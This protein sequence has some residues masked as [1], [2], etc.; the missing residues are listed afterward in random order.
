MSEALDMHVASREEQAA[1]HRNVFDIWSLGRSLDDHVAYRL[2]SP[3]HRLATWYVGCVDCRVVV[4]LGAYP[5]QFQLQGQRLPGFA[6]GSVYTIGDFRGRGYAPQL[7]SWVERRQWQ[8]GAALSLLYSDIKPEY[9]AR[10]GY[11]LCPSLEGRR[12]LAGD[13]PA[14]TDARLVEFSAA[15]HVQE[16]SKL[17][18]AYHG[19]LP[20]SIARDADYWQALLARMPDDRFFRLDTSAGPWQGYVRLARKDATWRITDYALAD[21][22]PTLAEQL[23]SASLHLARV[24]GAE[25]FGGWLPDTPAARKLFDLAPRQTEITMIK[26]LAAIGIPDEVIASA[27]HFCEV[28]HV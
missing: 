9:Y 19:A 21:H 4:S 20:L 28:D 7:I 17:Y 5:L 15:E 3:K 8:Q 14:V 6:I 12:E 27:G 10:Q 23:Y 16:L 18:D 13:E 22:S 24:E 26:P 2:D 1:A 25:R 11:V